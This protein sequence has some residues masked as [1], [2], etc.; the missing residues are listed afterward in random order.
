MKKVP[1]LSPER[2]N[3][4]QA[5]SEYSVEINLLDFVYAGFYHLCQETL[6]PGIVKPA[7]LRI[8]QNPEMVI[9]S[10]IVEE[11]TQ[12]SGLSLDH[13]NHLSLFRLVS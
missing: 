12:D 11:E 2:I 6:L 4:H 9:A 10:V 1:F 3:S 5:Q 13:N 7:D 8:G